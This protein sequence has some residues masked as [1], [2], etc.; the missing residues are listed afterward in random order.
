MYVKGVHKR[1]LFVAFRFRDDTNENEKE[2]QE[3]P[4]TDECLPEAT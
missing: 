4:I 1:Y 2:L 3:I